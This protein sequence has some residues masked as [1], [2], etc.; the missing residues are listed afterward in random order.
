MAVALIENRDAM[1]DT[2][3]PSWGARNSHSSLKS[4]RSGVSFR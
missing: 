1:L 4:V 2:D 3:C